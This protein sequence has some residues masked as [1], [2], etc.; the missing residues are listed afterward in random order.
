MYPDQ[1]ELR[2]SKSQPYL[3][4]SPTEDLL[5]HYQDSPPLPPVSYAS[6]R[7]AL[8]S[9]ETS[10]L[11]LDSIPELHLQHPQ[12]IRPRGANHGPSIS[13]FE[14]D[15]DSESTYSDEESQTLA[16]RIVRGLTGHKRGASENKRTARGDEAAKA[17]LQRARAET[18]D[19]TPVSRAGS[20]INATAQAGA[21]SDGHVSTDSSSGHITP[22]DSSSRSGENGPAGVN[23]AEGLSA[24]ERA[25][26]LGAG[27]AA[28]TARP[29]IK[30][31]GSDM[32]G[33]IFG[34]RSQ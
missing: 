34:R 33:R 10:D 4:I 31:Q 16:Q 32:F 15:S 29:R 17:Q 13:V 19:A 26:I 24:A 9:N 27:T 20:F 6:S 18:T 21:G 25:A 7:E 14:L 8:R 3:P 28:T 30:R 2:H 12:P 11:M 23:V 1:K 5:P 22:R